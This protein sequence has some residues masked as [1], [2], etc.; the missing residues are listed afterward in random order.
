MLKLLPGVVDTNA[1]EAPSWNLLD[2]PDDQRQEQPQLQPRLRRRSTTRTP[3]RREPRV[4]RAR[5]DCGGARPVVELPGRV[6]PQLGGVDHRHHAQRVEGLPRERRLLQARRRAERQRV[7]CESNSAGRAIGRVPAAAVPVRQLRVDAGRSRARARHGF[8][9]QRNR[10]FFFWSQERA[11][12]EPIR[13]TLNQ[14]RMPTALERAGDFSQTFDS[15]RPPDPHPRSAAL[16]ANCNA[17]TRRAGLF[18]GQRHPGR[19]DR[20]DGTGAPQPLSAAERVRPIGR[21]QYNYTFR[22]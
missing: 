11:G 20:P 10:L 1:R 3:T 5:L 15:A 9:R 17:A 8:N 4:A 12:A 19:P 6:R 2:R 13:V 14:R 21:N 16:R 22:W 7:L 18:P